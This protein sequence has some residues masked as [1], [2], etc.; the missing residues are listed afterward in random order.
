MVRWS[1]SSEG[2]AP[3][4]EISDPMSAI[5]VISSPAIRQA[6][7]VFRAIMLDDGLHLLHGLWAK[8]TRRPGVLPDREQ[9]HQETHIFG[10]ELHA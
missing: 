8:L 5:I 9:L 10:S 7:G 6:P 4:G 3:P 2:T 1:S